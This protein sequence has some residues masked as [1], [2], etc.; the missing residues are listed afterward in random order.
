MV[1]RQMRYLTLRIHYPN[2]EN[3][4]DFLAAVRK[5]SAES[6]KHQGLVEI[7]GLAG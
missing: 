1:M 5:V 4:Q 2:S 6:R 3:M 7:G